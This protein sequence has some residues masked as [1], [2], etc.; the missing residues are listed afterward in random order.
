ML[1]SFHH[2]T[3]VRAVDLVTWFDN[4]FA[5]R[6]LF[7]DVAPRDRQQ[8]RRHQTEFNQKRKQKFFRD[9][10]GVAEA[11]M[12]FTCPCE[13]KQSH[14]TWNSHCKRKNKFFSAV[15]NKQNRMAF[16]PF[17]HVLV[18]PVLF[19]WNCYYF[20]V[21]INKLLHKMWFC[22][23]FRFLYTKS[24]LQR[25][26]FPQYAHSQKTLYY[27]HQMFTCVR[28]SVGWMHIRRFICKNIGYLEKG[29]L[30]WKSSS[31]VKFLNQS[32]EPRN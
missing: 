5:R 23:V 31:D 3:I 29:S 6:R 18:L 17:S 20:L 25:R 7:F 8:A 22:A 14:Q 16:T 32:K 19:K 4:V 9:V 13:K 21:Y 12:A 27:L 28:R 2:I 24:I 26:Y 10:Y 1:R 11:R 30:A 15:V